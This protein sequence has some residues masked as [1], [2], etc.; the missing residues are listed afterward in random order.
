MTPGPVTPDQ[1]AG[2]LIIL[3]VGMVSTLPLYY[4]IT[5]VTKRMQAD[6]K[7]ALD[8]PLLA[9]AVLMVLLSFLRESA[10]RRK[11]R[12]RAAPRESFEWRTF[13]RWY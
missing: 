12:S 5:T 1:N 6:P 9:A 4:F 11:R 2:F 3:W 8:C 10:L 7:L 13:W